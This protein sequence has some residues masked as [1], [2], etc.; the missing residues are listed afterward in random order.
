MTQRVRGR[1][2]VMMLV[3]SIALAAAAPASRALQPEPELMADID[4]GAA[5]APLAAMMGGKFGPAGIEGGRGGPP[6]LPPFIHLSEQQQD[7]LFELRHA[8]EPALR[9]QFNELRD[10]RVQLRAL[11][12]AEGYDE[13][14]A[15]QIALRAAQASSEIELI[16]ARLQH[17]AFAVLTPEQRK[18]I[19]ECK[20]GTEATAC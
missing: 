10:A 15:K 2:Q 14:R 7:K 19:D 5:A 11:A 12:L 20:P 16:H 13:Q 9:T 18:R 17:A 8:Q 4:G 6:L 3:L 1:R